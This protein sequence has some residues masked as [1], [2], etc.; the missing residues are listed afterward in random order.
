MQE[1]YRVI[2]HGVKEGYVPEMVADLLAMLFK[3]SKQEILP[4]LR[5]APVTVKKGVQFAT[6]LRY[7]TAL[8]Q[9]GCK[10]S[11]EPDA[12]TDG[13]LATPNR[14]RSIK[15]QLGM[16]DRGL[17]L[18]IRLPQHLCCNCAAREGLLS[19]ATGFVRSPMI[20]ALLEPQHA[21]LLNL[22]YCPRCVSRLARSP[23]NRLL[24]WLLALLVWVLGTLV[25]I[26]KAGPAPDNLMLKFGV[27]ILPLLPALS[28][29]WFSARVR[30]PQT[31]RDTPVAIRYFVRR[32][33]ARFDTAKIDRN[34][35]MF[36]VSIKM[37]N[38]AYAN[39]FQKSNRARI[40]RRQIRMR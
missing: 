32:P 10:C 6:A 20:P 14:A 28:V 5:T 36:K 3:R 26:V 23:V 22:P 37:S 15:I 30:A 39:A 31:S 29:L 33:S 21:L 2:T 13:V 16:I 11:V 7:K 8:E 17:P 27:V 1:T 12:A 9:R 18:E 24:V 34:R 38:S 4:L 25:L 35:P 40:A 19:V